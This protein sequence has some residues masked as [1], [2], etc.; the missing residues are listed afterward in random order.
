MTAPFGQNFLHKWY[1]SFCINYMQLWDVTF[2]V[3]ICLISA[4]NIVA[5]SIPYC[6]LWNVQD[7]EL[8]IEFQDCDYKHGL[9][10]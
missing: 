2:L 7:Y 3:V 4:T 8:N 1:S 10:I 9:I 5:R 6:S